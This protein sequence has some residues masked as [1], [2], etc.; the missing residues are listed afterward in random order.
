MSPFKKVLVVLKGHVIDNGVTEREFTF[1]PSDRKSISTT[2]DTIWA[3]IRTAS[4]GCEDTSISDIESA[5]VAAAAVEIHLNEAIMTIEQV[6]E[7]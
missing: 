6:D 7:D 3:F 1:D 4:Y 5:M 2:S